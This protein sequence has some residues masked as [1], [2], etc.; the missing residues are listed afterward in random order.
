MDPFDES[1]V[2]VEPGEGLGTQYPS[3]IVSCP[4]GSG[5]KLKVTLELDG[6]EASIEVLEGPKDETEAFEDWL[7]DENTFQ[8][9]YE[10][11][12]YQDAVKAFRS[13]QETGV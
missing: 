6:R 13:D 5:L 12:A 1:D 7:A 2:T 11:K 10:S 9:I 8:V 3:F 4:S